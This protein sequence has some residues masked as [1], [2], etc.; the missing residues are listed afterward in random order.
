MDLAQKNAD[1]LDAVI[2]KAGD[3]VDEKTGDKFTGQV[4]AAQN[5]AKKALREK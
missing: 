4:D 1:K 3:L 2:D 5:A